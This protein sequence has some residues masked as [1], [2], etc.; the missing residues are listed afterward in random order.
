M[1]LMWKLRLAIFLFLVAA[2]SFGYYHNFFLEYSVWSTDW[3][4]A[5]ADSVGV[6]V[7]VEENEYNQVAE[8][9]KERANQLDSREQSL[10]ELEQEIKAELIAERQAERRAFLFLS[11]A[12]V[13]LMA[14]LAVNFYLDWRRSERIRRI[15]RGAYVLRNK[16]QRSRIGSSV[17]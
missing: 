7:G 15:K 9:L 1:K 4:R 10:A 12:S 2:G 5:A 17:G 11:V 8:Q 3:G 13:V 16:D 6:S 14:L